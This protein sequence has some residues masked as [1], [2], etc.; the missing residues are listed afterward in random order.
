LAS[1]VIV[2]TGSSRGLGRAIALR[3]GHAGWRVAVHCRTRRA[4]AEAV[5][6]AIVEAGGDALVVASDVTTP[7][8]LPDLVEVTMAK[9]GRIDA[10]VNNAGVVD[11]R[12]VV[13]MPEDA[14]D[15][16]IATDLSAAWRA[17]RAVVPVMR[18]QGGGSI[19]NVASIAA[20][21][22]RRGQ[23]AYSAAKAGLIALTR[24]AAAELGPDSIRVNAVC[25]PVLDTESAGA[26]AEAL[27]A[28]QLIAGAV[29]LDSAGAA[30]FTLLTL[31]WITGQTIV[32]DS[33]IPAGA[34]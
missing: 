26:H 34:L 7:N 19:L 17:T 14:W 13:S 28:D 21:Q 25:P 11:D 20:L 30:V 6:L 15:R 24:A 4:D 18:Q 29:S 33:R 12:L 16:V 2:V 27:R 8:A 31:P 3:S 22:G 1:P 9:W 32:M 10:W 5:A 23:S